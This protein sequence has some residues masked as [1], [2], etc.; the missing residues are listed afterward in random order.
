MTGRQ[1]G[2]TF[3]KNTP[4]QNLAIPEEPGFDP[5][6]AA[7]SFVFSEQTGMRARHLYINFKLL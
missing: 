4:G 5:R 2:R 1:A 6:Q 7:V 3:Q